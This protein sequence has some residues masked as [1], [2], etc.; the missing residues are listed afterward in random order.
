[1]GSPEANIA[2]IALSTPV[3]V[4]PHESILPRSDPV[5]PR[6][7]QVPRHHEGGCGGIRSRR[8][9]APSRRVTGSDACLEAVDPRSG[10]VAETGVVLPTEFVGRELELTVL[11]E[12]LDA[13][14]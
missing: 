11:H 4:V 2:T 14:A 5:P 1:M 3:A 10:W 8:H 12:C 9:S 7:C 6:N 13:G